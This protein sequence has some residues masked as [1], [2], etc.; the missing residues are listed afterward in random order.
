MPH[1]SNTLLKMRGCDSSSFLARV[2]F[3]DL[4]LQYNKRCPTWKANDCQE[5]TA[6]CHNWKGHGFQEAID[7]ADT[8][9][10]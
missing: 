10:L 4:L 9:H 2:I 7:T 8:I 6:L 5:A 3:V 1:F